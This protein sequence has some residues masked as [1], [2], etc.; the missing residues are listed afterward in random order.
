MINSIDIMSILP[1]DATVDN[2]TNPD[3]VLIVLKCLSVYDTDASCN[4]G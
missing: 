1:S 3:R 4:G 2:S